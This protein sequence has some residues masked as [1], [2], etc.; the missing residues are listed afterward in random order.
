MTQSNQRVDGQFQGAKHR[1]TPYNIT[2]FD[3]V[4]DTTKLALVSGW[5]YC[6]RDATFV[7]SNHVGRLEHPCT[8]PCGLWSIKHTWFRMCG[9]DHATRC[10]NDR[11]PWPPRGW[12]HTQFLLH[13]I[14]DEELTKEREKVIAD[15]L[16]GVHRKTA[17]AMHG[18]AILEKSFGTAV[19]VRPGRALV[20]KTFV[21]QARSSCQRTMPHHAESVNSSIRTHFRIWI[22]VFNL[23]VSGPTSFLNSGGHS[24]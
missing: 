18:A 17:D 12:L 11:Y 6:F 19:M 1:M 14:P 9:S 3:T 13:Q 2:A 15:G 22:S 16:L 24:F 23:C 8:P 7:V 5:Q 10:S 20:T 4:I 21:S